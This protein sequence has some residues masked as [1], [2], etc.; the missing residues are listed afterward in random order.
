MK[1][2]IPCM[3]YMGSALM[4][5]NILH[6][7]LFTK[8]MKNTGVLEMRRTFMYLPFFLLIFFLIGYLITA[9]FGNPTLV[10][11]GILLGGSVF[12]FLILN[13][14]IH[15]VG[16][17]QNDETRVSALYNELREELSSI[18]KDRLAVF[19]VN[20]TKDIIED[21]AGIDLYES[22]MK[23]RSYTELMTARFPDML[24]KPAVSY[25][26]G[27]FT[28][29]GL[30]EHF[31]KGHTYASET[32]YA[33]RKSVRNG[34]FLMEASL[35]QQPIT[36]EVIAFIT[37]R[38]YNNDMID[39]T[40]WNKALCEQYDG[41]AYIAS[42]QFGVVLHSNAENHPDLLKID[43]EESYEDYVLR[44]TDSLDFESGEERL[45][46]RAALGLERVE[47]EL[48]GKE[49][50]TVDFSYRCVSDTIY[51][52][53]TYF[54]AEGEAH[55]YALLISDTTEIRREQAE[56]TRVLAEALEQ[57]E[58][59]NAAKTTFL[60]NMSHDIR[61]PMNAIIGYTT[62]ALRDG[63]TEEEMRDFLNK[64][65]SSSQYLLALIN[66][67]L[68]MSRI[69]SGKI[70]LELAEV[71]LKKA[72][73]EVRDMFSTQ[74]KSKRIDFTVDA[75]QVKNR[76]V[77]CDSN[78]FNRVLLNL[79]SNA[80]KFTPEGGTVSLS[81][82]Q[83]EDDADGFGKYELR[84]KDSGIGMAPE[85]AEKVFEAFEREHTSTVSG[86]QGTGLGMS[87]T[88]SIIDLMGGSIE[89]ITAPGAGTEF[90]VRVKFALAAD[91]ET[92]AVEK[93][94]KNEAPTLD[95]SK[96][97]L[98]L[99]DDN[100]INREIATMI[101]EGVGF[102]L[103]TAENGQ[104]AVEKVSASQPGE[105][106]AVLMDVQMPVMNGYEATKT[107][108]GLD[109]PALANLPIIAM[110]ANAFA[111]DIR[112]AKEAGMDGHI[113]KPIDVDK[114]MVELTKILRR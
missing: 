99:V 111:E 66:D 65:D 44:L 77:L 102:A 76:Y 85:F 2:V 52:R 86:I 16:H 113:A 71:D 100:E 19:R 50:Y 28:R 81:L 8:K 98:L 25:G 38:D 60:S 26:P 97:R 45:R 110:T 31:H 96:M 46:V 57:A 103:D 83:I 84:V 108:R 43:V 23:A 90:I 59:S 3:I 64:I 36:G 63:R 11:A 69:E 41:I 74:M 21:R 56:Q 47:Q 109:N 5:Y 92:S 72:L 107:I 39:R 91:G 27:L 33:R 14:M 1:F 12:V 7:Y 24:I 29:E 51:K 42:G 48:S 53:F 112:A 89:V 55:F 68:E 82:W 40:I 101:L 87:I 20:L 35:A 32:V 49:S 79:I 73:L 75:S 105:F 88:K 22:D 67:V 80:Y 9:L 10:M 104:I 34:Y 114:M 78:R 4:V 62:L 70:D 17:I 94:A 6:Y 15:I 13:V 106:D 95:F 18:T 37:E 58:A 54:A 93:E 30:L 61:T